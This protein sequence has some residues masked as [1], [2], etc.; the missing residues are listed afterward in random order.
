MPHMDPVTVGVF[1]AY[2]LWE[3][4][5]GNTDQIKASNTIDLIHAGVTYLLNLF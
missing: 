2:S 1:I 3:K 5:L 4:W